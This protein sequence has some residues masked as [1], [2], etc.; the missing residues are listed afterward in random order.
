MGVSDGWHKT[1]VRGIDLKN[2]R[3][4][5]NPTKKYLLGAF[6]ILLVTGAG[7]VFQFGLYPRF[8]DIEWD[9]QVQ[10]H[11]GRVIV[12]HVK[13]FYERQSKKLKPYDESNIMFRRKVLTFESEPGK[14]YTFSTRMPVAYLGQFEK[15]WYVVISGQG[16]Y[17]NH[18][19]EMPNHWGSDFTTLEQRLAVLQDGVFRP[20]RWDGA[21]P[22]LTKMNLVE[23]AFFGD[24]VAWSGKLLTLDQKRVFNDRHPTP[25]RQEITRP[26]RLQKD[27]V[28]K[29]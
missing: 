28:G 15:D 2:W 12:V 4:Q 7:Y 25:Y 5:L 1:L 16:P 27:Q 13:N 17:G 29:K 21:P 22:Q 6:F 8:F 18:S 11:D 10:M 9:E 26:I 20:A 23:S 19:D 24:F 14:R 3:K